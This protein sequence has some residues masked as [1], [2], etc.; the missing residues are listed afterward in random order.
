MAAQE[1]SLKISQEVQSLK[2]ELHRQ[3][4]ELTSSRLEVEDLKA[5]N[6]RLCELNKECT[7]RYLNA[8]K[9]TAQAKTAKSQLE[10]IH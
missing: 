1:R 4:T 7:S 2:H 3:Q 5:N 8:E 10:V 6:T 9:L